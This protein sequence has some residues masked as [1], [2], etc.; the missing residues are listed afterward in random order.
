M[1]KNLEDRAAAHLV[2]LRRWS[3][4]VGKALGGTRTELDRRH[5]DPSSV[6]PA[7]WAVQFGAV[8]HVATAR[9]VLSAL[10]AEQDRIRAKL[11][12]VENPADAATYEAALRAALISDAALRVQLRLAQERVAATEARI[13]AL[14]QLQGV[15]QGALAAGE[16]ELKVA[17]RRQ[18]DGQALRAALTT[19]PLDTLVADAT[20]L[21]TGATSSAAE[22]RLE[23]LLPDQLRSRALTRAAEADALSASAATHETAGLAR[24]DK[25]QV[26]GAPLDGA[27]EAAARAFTQAEEDLRRYVH[28]A[29]ADLVIAETALSTVAEK[30]ALDPAARAE[31]VK[32]AGFE[33][34]LAT[35]VAALTKAQGAVDNAILDALVTDPDADPA[36]NPDV[37]SAISTRDAAAIQDPLAK[38]RTDY[39][40]AR[41]A[42]DGWEVEV[43]PELWRGLVQ[44]AAA[45]GTLTRLSDQ[46]ARDALST[47]LDTRQDALAAALD[48]RD[49]QIRR[50]LAVA[51]TL[52]A[53]TGDAAATVATAAE[54]STQYL[55]GDGP[56]G[57]T[58]AQL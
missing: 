48:A 32:A 3:D 49:A 50:E 22:N 2:L 28:T 40:A 30:A 57:R 1:T 24:H 47:G 27:L 5:P 36:T 52:V 54:R 58:P 13:S 39:A 44:F 12:A 23:A 17:A 15:A 29:Q 21:L 35:A 41:A 37:V 16:A 26:I 20:H 8:Q 31:A 14:A 38:A 56:G 10:R 19:A 9:A 11:A 46:A 34:A 51:L 25:A 7:G 6:D 53:R 42:L 43:P 33:G 4:E 45:S 55:R 18:V